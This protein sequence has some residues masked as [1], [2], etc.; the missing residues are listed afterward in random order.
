LS[1]YF[2]IT[3][4]WDPPTRVFDDD[5]FDLVEA[6]NFNLLP[7]IYTNLISSSDQLD[8]AAAR[9]MQTL[10]RW[11]GDWNFVR[12]S[13]AAVDQ[14]AA[15]MAERYAARDG[16][17]GYW[18]TDEPHAD[19]F[20][21]LARAH[22]QLLANDPYHVPYE[23]LYPIYAS[24]EQLGRS[25]YD[26]YVRDYMATVRPKVLCYDNY[27]LTH[28]SYYRNMEII[29]KYAVQYNVPFWYV[30]LSSQHLGYP[31][32]NE[33]LLRWQVFSALAYGAKGISYYTYWCR[34]LDDYLNA[35][36]NKNG[37]L[38]AKYHQAKAINAE[39][40]V[41]GPILGRLKSRAVYHSEAPAYTSGISG[42]GWVTSLSGGPAIIGELQ[43]DSGR[44]L[45]ITNRDSSSARTFRVSVAG[46]TTGVA[47]VDKASATGETVPMSLSGGSFQITLAAGN[48]EL[49]KL[50]P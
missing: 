20:P 24:S 35:L 21:M 14:A 27:A 50:T 43:G 17:F 32:P 28:S 36:V 38:D 49:F 30:L 16:M 6:A 4:W 1:S 44:Y 22:Q 11:E 40:Q 13:A 19:E 26:T 7:S 37:S 33:A 47:R 25:D 46:G 45:M 41:L 48:G 9:G 31:N 39:L 5:D 42:S 34:E 2:A 10:V 23:N 15:T 29:R 18:L 8:Y 3:F 12:I